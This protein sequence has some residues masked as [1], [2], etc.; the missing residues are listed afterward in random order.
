MISVFSEKNTTRLNYVLAFFFE[1]KGFEY[2]V[3]NSLEDWSKIK[4]FRINY[5]LQ[6]IPCELQIIPSGL[7]F[8][9]KIETDIR[10]T[11]EGGLLK[12][13][14]FT[15]E[16]ALVFWMLTRMEEYYTKIKLDEH[17]RYVSNQSQL[18]INQLHLKPQADIL[19]KSIWLK[20]G[21]NY[22]V[23][24]NRFEGVPSFDIDVAWAYKN[25]SFFRTLAAGLKHGKFVER[26]SVLI[27]K[28]KDPYD[29]YETIHET[30]TKVKRII[31]FC[32]LGDHS[33]YDKNIH[34][35]NFNY[36]SLIRSL[37][38]VGGMGIH[39]SYYT[40]N[41][42]AKLEEEIFRLEQIVGHEI[43]KSRQHFLRLSI[44]DTYNS[45][46]EKGIQ[47]DF[48]MGFADNIGF[49]AGTSFPYFFYDLKTEQQTN[50]LIFPFAYMD[51]VLKDKLNLSP[52]QAI[53]LNTQ[54]IETVK[55]VGGVFMCIWHNSSIG[56]YAEWKGWKAVFDH[57]V[58]LLENFDQ[59]DF[60]EDYF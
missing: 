46:I 42:K 29:T 44:P 24:K 9:N 19:I 17:E 32:L 50:L 54:L 30:A 11:V 25:R 26:F 47:R 15:D 1:Q 5:S 59:A 52:T 20:L 31:C 14:Q 8:E 58:L 40:K 22:E 6:N 28:S 41:N 51:G 7:L 57:T 12:L 35:K 55:D 56:D 16:F 37:N 38:S 45:L 39:P 27:G 23:V 21:L 10:L 13:N 43:V 18:V 4:S 49:R 3:I 34:W 2:Q 36:Q 53:E 60:N 48:S 33:K